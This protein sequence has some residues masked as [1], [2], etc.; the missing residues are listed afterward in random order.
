MEN[1]SFHPEEMEE[2]ISNASDLPL[3]EDPL[4]DAAF[5]STLS[6]R[7]PSNFSHLGVFRLPWFQRSRH[8][9]SKILESNVPSQSSSTSPFLA[10]PLW[11]TMLA[12]GLACVCHRVVAGSMEGM[13]NKKAA[14]P[15][16]PALAQNVLKFSKGG[17]SFGALCCSFYAA[18]L[19]GDM[20]SFP[21]CMLFG[22]MKCIYNRTIL[23][24]D[25]IRILPKLKNA[26]CSKKK[27]P[28]TCM[29][30]F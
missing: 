10:L 15:T 24:K 26:K 30:I 25:G 29:C 11:Q 1:L 8:P 18:A 2:I 23:E 12:G 14:R 6:T 19:V 17:F 9:E 4:M 20:A 21:D 16:V 27:Y 7:G 5:L 28:C 22:L 13:L 3:P